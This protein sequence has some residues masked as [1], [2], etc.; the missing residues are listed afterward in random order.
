MTQVSQV[1]ASD[2]LLLIAHGSARYPDAAR[3]LRGHAAALRDAGCFSQVEIGLLNGTPSVTEA[4]NKS[5]D[6]TICV[7][8][9]FMEEGYF[10]RIAIPRLL[11]TDQRVRL[12]P[13]VGIHPGLADIIQAQAQRACRARAIPLREAAILLV[14][15][16]S[17][18]APGRALALHRHAASVA[19]AAMFARCE[20]ACLEEAPL[21]ADALQAL[22][23]HP[24]IV[25]GFFAGEGMH[26]RDDVPKA[27]EAE[28]SARGENGCP[29]YFPGSV[30]DDR[31]MTRIVL[32]QAGAC[33]GRGN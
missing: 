26:V 25:I 30:T 22:R 24:V 8:P 29:V 5:R 7:V 27:I 15:H 14:G 6:T 2:I 3:V 17:A 32:D 13:A 33:D 4:L 19:S 12:C 10:T 11:G 31:A 23:A 18:S 9:F 21:L 28:R 1:L 20:A 16:G